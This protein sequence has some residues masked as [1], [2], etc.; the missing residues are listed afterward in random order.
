MT[1]SIL[2]RQSLTQQ[3]LSE[4][5]IAYPFQDDSYNIFQPKLFQA[6]HHEERQHVASQLRHFISLHEHE[7]SLFLTLHPLVAELD[8]ELFDYDTI[9]K[10]ILTFSEKLTGRLEPLNEQKITLHVDELF[11]FKD[12]LSQ[13]SYLIYLGLLSHFIDCDHDNT[14]PV[15]YD[16]YY[17]TIDDI[18]K[19]PTKY[20][21]KFQNLK[22][23]ICII[24]PYFEISY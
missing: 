24:N 18:I 7:L 4:M 10:K 1:I 14:S 21:T 19:N 2:K 15:N 6:L 17:A 13:Q 5:G 16:R 23:N 20:E 8:T 12:D 22:D 11:H 3:F 9:Q